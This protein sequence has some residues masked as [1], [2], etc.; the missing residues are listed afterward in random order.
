MNNELEFKSKLKRTLK[1]LSIKA[2]DLSN[3]SIDDFEK[4]LQICFII[5]KTSQS[6][7]FFINNFLYE[8]VEGILQV[9]EGVKRFAYI[10]YTERDE[11]HDFVNFTNDSKKVTQAIKNAEYT[12]GN[13]M[14][15][16]AN[17]ALDLFI[18]E[19]LFNPKGT[20]I[21]IHVTDM[22]CHGNRFH[23]K[24]VHDYHPDWSENLP[25]R[26]RQIANNLEC[27][28]WFVRITPK[29][30]QMIDEFNKILNEKCKTEGL[31]RINIIDLARLKMN[32]SSIVKRLAKQAV[33]VRMFRSQ[34]IIPS[35]IISGSNC[36]ENSNKFYKL[37]K[38]LI[39]YRESYLKQYVEYNFYEILEAF[40]K[41]EL[42]NFSSEILFQI[43]SF[44]IKIILIYFLFVCLGGIQ[45]E[46][47]QIDPYI[48]RILKEYS[49]KSFIG[50]GAFGKVYLV[51]EESKK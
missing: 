8:I 20:R 46:I 42:A 26:L 23:D 37:L 24:T 34:D 10:G 29:T 15:Q 30:D 31:N 47:E 14:A 48:G 17:F 38:L 5:N 11:P 44:L 33:V 1:D 49:I 2:E 28:Y 4:D 27:F 12:G 7:Y 18:N 43:S 40:R 3:I 16:D 6:R 22:P 25:D 45:V 51:R 50:K 19:I 36:V 9:S 13:D 21:I 32:L 39:D 41:S 35:F